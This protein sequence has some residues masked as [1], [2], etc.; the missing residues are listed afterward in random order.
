MKGLVGQK[1]IAFKDLCMFPDVHLP[2]GF[3][4]PKF[5]LYDEHGNLVAHLR[6]YCSEM[7]SV[8]GKKDLLMAHFSE[9]L[10]GAALEWHTRQDVSKWHTWGDMAQDFVRHY[11][12]NEN[13]IPDRPSL[14]QIEKKPKES[15]R[16]FWFRWNKQ[17]A[18]RI[19]HK[20]VWE[21]KH[22]GPI[23]PL[24]GYTLDPYA[25]G[26]DPTVRCM[27]HSNVQGHGIKDCR[28][29]K[30]EIERMI[31]EGIIVIKDSDRGYSNP[32]GNLLTKVN[33]IEVG[34]GLDNIDVELSV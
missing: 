5:N 10:I 19:L 6:G 34:N 30:R 24:L 29:L 25:K 13:I 14:S 21:V 9:S 15:F 3:K 28:A 7:R 32:F 20:P 31:Q 8:G 22:S 16:E 2:P 11:Q 27:H 26:F 18:R 33:N 4:I 1:S 17:V 23:E 12:N